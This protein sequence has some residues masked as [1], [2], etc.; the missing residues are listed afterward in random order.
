MTTY[1]VVPVMFQSKFASSRSLWS[2]CRRWPLCKNEL[3]LPQKCTQAG[4][5]LETGSCQAQHDPQRLLR[6][7]Y[8][9][10]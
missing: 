3:M 5:K 9:S 7:A 4:I 6:D 10:H 2:Q 1:P 8:C